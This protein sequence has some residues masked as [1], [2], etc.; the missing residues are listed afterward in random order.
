MLKIENTNL[1]KKYLEYCT[2]VLNRPQTEGINASDLLLQRNVRV[3]RVAALLVFLTDVFWLITNIRAPATEKLYE[4]AVLLSGYIHIFLAA[5]LTIT[6]FLTNKITNKNRALLNCIFI[7]FYVF[8]I[9]HVAL[10]AINFDNRAM[11]AGADAEYVG[12]AVSTFYLF[13][14]A[15]APMYEW[16]Y[17]LML[18]CL[19][20]IGAILPLMVDSASYYAVAEQFLLRLFLIA[21]YLLIRSVNMRLISHEYYLMQLTA[22][23][24]V[25][26]YVDNLTDVLNRR[27]METY[28]NYM[29]KDLGIEDVGVLLFDVDNF[30]NFN[31]T[32]SHLKGDEALCNVCTAVGNAI[33]DERDV[34]LF[35]YGG[36]EFVILYP[37]PNSANMNRIAGKIVKAVYD[38]NMPR[39]DIEGRDR[40]TI[41]VGCAMISIAEVTTKDYLKAADKQTYIGKHSGKNC[42][43][44]DGTVIKC[45]E[46]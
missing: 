3:M 24:T 22:D 41:T 46:I 23:L 12:I 36:E 15:F 39:N 16:Y 35:R 9:F 27:A 11:A 34:F 28:W 43:V 40:V 1:E 45:S 38:M 25:S 13:V 20:I 33:A 10:Y 2:N 8:T 17:T 19:T 29:S 32:Y 6:S 14:I 21:A 31:D 37:E 18:G 7:I 30:K 26:S 42:Y 5:L 4:G 44:I